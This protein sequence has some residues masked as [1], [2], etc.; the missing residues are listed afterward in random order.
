M[1]TN[2]FSYYFF[3]QELDY[4]LNAQ[5]YN[6]LKVEQKNIRKILHLNYVSHIFLSSKIRTINRQLHVKLTDE[7]GN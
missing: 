6:S 3:T 4:Y 1:T 5:Y 2:R 7:T